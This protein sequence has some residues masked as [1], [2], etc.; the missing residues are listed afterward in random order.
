[1]QAV[2]LGIEALTGAEP[3]AGV[4]VQPDERVQSC[5]G[6]VLLFPVGETGKSSKPSPIGGARVGTEAL[7]ETLSG[8]C[9]EFLG[10]NAGVLKPCLEVS[11][12][13]FDHG[14]RLEALSVEDGDGGATEVIQ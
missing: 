3:L 2:R 9:A 14:A 10:K 11:W 7:G 4:T 1:M 12:A 13:G 5:S 6:P 8:K